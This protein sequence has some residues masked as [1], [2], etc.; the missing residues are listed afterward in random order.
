MGNKKESNPRIIPPIGQ[1]SEPAPAHSPAH[2]IDKAILSRRGF[3]KVV[4][5]FTLSAS[6]AGL[7]GK[8]VPAAAATEFPASVGYILVDSAKCQGCLTCMISCSLAH[9][10][11]VN[12]SLARIQVIQNP[13]AGW[14]DDITIE[15]CHHCLEADCVKAC[16]TGALKVDAQNGN[17]RLVDNTLCVGCGLCVQACPAAVERP[18]LA[19]DPSFDDRLKSRKCDLC[20]NASHH[21]IPGGGGY[22]GVQVCAA[23][24]PMDAIKFTTTMPTQGGNAGYDVNMRDATWEQLGF[25]TS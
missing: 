13:F 2:S 7:I 10:G 14:P 19:K 16:P 24:C 11:C 4:G 20:Q 5:I 18:I 8:S 21:Y 17:T 3:I 1:Q 9:E 12:L 6:S 25:S 23:V 22:K 15:Q